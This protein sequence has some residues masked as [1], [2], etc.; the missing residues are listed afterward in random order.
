MGKTKY[1]FMDIQEKEVM[2]E[3]N[4]WIEEGRNPITGFKVNKKRGAAEDKNVIRKEEGKY[5]N[6]N[7]YYLFK[8]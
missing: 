7:G 6:P 2:S 8:Q 4:K 5:E 3:V 1:W